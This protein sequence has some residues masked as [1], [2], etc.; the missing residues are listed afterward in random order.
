MRVTKS[1]SIV[2]GVVCTNFR[3]VPIDFGVVDGN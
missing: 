3:E 1:D 2:A